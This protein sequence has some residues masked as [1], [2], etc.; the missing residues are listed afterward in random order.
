MPDHKRQSPWKK[1]RK[2]ERT[3]AEEEDKLG[4]YTNTISPLPSLLSSPTLVSPTPL[5]LISTTCIPP[6]ASP[7]LCPSLLA[8][9]C[10]SR[11]GPHC[12]RHPFPLHLRHSRSILQKTRSGDSNDAMFLFFCV[13]VCVYISVLSERC[14]CKEIT[15]GLDGQT[16]RRSDCRMVRW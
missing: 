2:K 10:S 16:V 5:S 8:L 12:P 11:S 3:E 7:S 13:C 1:E 14:S 6:Q 9:V 4:V 15:I